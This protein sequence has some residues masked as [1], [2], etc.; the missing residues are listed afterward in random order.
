M[1]NADQWDDLD[2]DV[3]AAVLKIRQRFHE[4][5]RRIGVALTDFTHRSPFEEGGRDET[6]VPCR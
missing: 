6:G 4:A 3:N 2:R 5:Q 1:T